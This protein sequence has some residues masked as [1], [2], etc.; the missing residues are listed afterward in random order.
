MKVVDN[1]LDQFFS[2]FHFKDFRVPDCR[3]RWKEGRKGRRE[4]GGGGE[5][6][7]WDLAVN[8]NF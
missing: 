6:Y 5:I 3:V 2:N 4:E 8:F 1:V 7:I